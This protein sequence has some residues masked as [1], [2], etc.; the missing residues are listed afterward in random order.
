MEK[1]D[2]GSFMDKYMTPIAVLV[3]ALIIAGAF[4]FGR[5][6]AGLTGQQGTE[7]TVAVNIADVKENTGPYIG[8]KN[9]PTTMAVWYDYQCGHCKNYDG[10]TLKE[11]KASHVDT[12]KLRIL[13]KDFQFFPGSEEVAVFGRAMWEAYPDQHYAWFSGVMALTVDGQLTVAQVKQVAAG[14]PGVDA[15]Q[16]AQLAT[17]KRDAYLA[18]VKA[19]REE[20]GTFGVTGTPAT[21]VG[22]Q[23]LGGAQPYA[24]VSA[25]VDEAK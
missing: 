5:G 16:V 22:K 14:I 25:A 19:D 2:T 1:V 7:P 6:E 9:A 23:M 11:L 4:A 24:V 3:G 20:G 12:G 10:T 15:E 21:I 8:D 13:L 18:A 17:Q